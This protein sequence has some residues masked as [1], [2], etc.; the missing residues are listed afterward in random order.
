MGGQSV[1]GIEMPLS[2]QEQRLLDEMERHLM[3]HGD[4]VV[5]PDGSRQISYRHVVLGAL[6]A[7]L[8]IAG[9]VVAVAIYASAGI[10]A[11]IL[12]GVV[13]FALMVLGVVLAF[14]LTDAPDAS[15]AAPAS[16]QP[17][18]RAPGGSFSD[19]MND[20]WEKRQDER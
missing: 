18:G 3:G 14:S 7:I 11:T 6:F 13:G 4:H 19:R 8:G 16:P 20:R 17:S 10:V 1:K 2:E 12:V 5:V 9:I 15:G